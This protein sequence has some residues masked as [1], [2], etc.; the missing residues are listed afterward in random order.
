MKG[1]RLARNGSNGRKARHVQ[2]AKPNG[3]GRSSTASRRATKKRLEPEALLPLS[4]PMFLI[5]LALS[6]RE[7]HGYGII[8]SVE[9]ATHGGVRLRTGTLYTAIA[10]MVDDGLI[11]ETVSGPAEGGDERRRYYRITRFGR[12]VARAEA[13]RLARLT[14]LAKTHGFLRKRRS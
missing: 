8:I 3:K 7:L 9:D 10:R 11:R 4:E 5:L 2:S 6:D 12:A 13:G 14:A 1:N